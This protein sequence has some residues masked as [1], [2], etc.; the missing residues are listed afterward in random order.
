MLFMGATNR[1]VTIDEDYIVSRI[2]FCIDGSQISVGD[3][4][5]TL[6]TYCYQ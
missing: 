5:G 1:I 4:S 6:V 3:E 2:L